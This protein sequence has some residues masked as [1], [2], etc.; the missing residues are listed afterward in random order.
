MNPVFFFSSLGAGEIFNIVKAEFRR[1]NCESSEDSKRM[2][3]PYYLNR[4]WSKPRV[5]STWHAACVSKQTTFTAP[6]MLLLH[7]SS[8]EVDVPQQRSQPPGHRWSW[9]TVR[10]T[11][12]Q[13]NCD[14]SLLEVTFNE[15]RKREKIKKQQ[16]IHLQSSLFKLL[17]SIRS[18]SSDVKNL[19]GG[20]STGESN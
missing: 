17:A 12:L 9:C 20:E 14:V 2:W 19:S 16:W 10:S 15:D 3:S 4:K 18:R 5:F 6:P 13:F 8:S 11:H 1:R 7:T